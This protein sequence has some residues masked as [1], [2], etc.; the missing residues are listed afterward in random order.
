[1]K[2]ATISNTKEL[3]FIFLQVT[4]MSSL[5]KDIWILLSASA[6]ILSG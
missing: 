6:S 1:M 5:E 3:Y 4:L 2:I